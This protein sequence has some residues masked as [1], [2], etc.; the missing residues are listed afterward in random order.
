M[1]KKA[2]KLA[3][4]KGIIACE[5]EQVLRTIKD[6]LT[7]LT[8]TTASTG[9]DHLVAALLQDKK[10]TSRPTSEKDIADLQQS[11]DEIFG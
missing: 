1:D 2:L 6:I 4:I 9:Q 10:A 7:N 8:P 3:L 11:I 5:D